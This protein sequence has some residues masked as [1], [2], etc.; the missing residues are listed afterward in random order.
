MIIFSC[1]NGQIFD[2]LG[3]GN[4]HGSSRRLHSAKISEKLSNIHEVS[5]NFKLYYAI[6][7][8]NLMGDQPNIHGLK[9]LAPRIRNLASDPLYDN[10]FGRERPKRG[11]SPHLHDLEDVDIPNIGCGRNFFEILL[12]GGLVNSLEHLSI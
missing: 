4:V 2:P 3:S 9:A 1:G 10:R 11:R 8:P 6:V 5:P 7:W 12:R